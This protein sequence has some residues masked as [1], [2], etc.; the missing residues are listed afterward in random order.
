MKNDK[1]ASASV[2][3]FLDKIKLLKTCPVSII[4]NLDIIGR[5]FKSRQWSFHPGIKDLNFPS[6]LKPGFLFA[7]F[8]K[9][10][11]G[12][13][14]KMEEIVAFSKQ[15]SLI[16][17]NALG[18]GSLTYCSEQIPKNTIFYGFD[19]EKNLWKVNDNI[20]AKDIV[21]V[22]ILFLNSED[23]CSLIVDDASKELNNS[24]GF[25]IFSEKPFPKELLKLVT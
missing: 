10:Q 2:I 3:N 5:E 20:K 12:Q 24:S 22:P 18:L 9:V 8:F 1:T 11:T 6:D 16:L 14:I 17:P 4:P 21:Y 13:R 25:V 23:Y 7:G 19:E 15:S